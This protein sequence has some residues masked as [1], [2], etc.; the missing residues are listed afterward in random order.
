M[1][2]QTPPVYA[3]DPLGNKPAN[4]VRGERHTI[5]SRNHYDFNYVIPTYAPFYV[6]DFKIYTVTQQGAKQYLV[7]GVDYVFALRYTQATTHG[8]KV[9]YGA[10]SFLNRLFTGE[11]YLEYRTVGG[12]F[13]IDVNKIAFI[14]AEW[15]HNPVSTTWEQVADPPSHFPPI[16]H[17]HSVDDLTQVKDLVDAIKSL[18]FEGGGGGGG[19]IPPGT[20]SKA[21][22]GL[23]NVLNLP[24]LPRGRGWDRTDNYYM[25]PRA[26]VEVIDSHLGDKLRGNIDATTLNGSTKNEILE[27]AREST[28]NNSK[29]LENKTLN[30]IKNDISQSTLK[31]IS[32]NYVQLAARPSQLK[33]VVDPSSGQVIQ[34]AISLGKVRSGL[35]SAWVDDVDMGLIQM[36][37][38]TIPINVPLNELRTKTDMGTYVVTLNP[39][40][41]DNITQRNMPV[42]EQ[43]YLH[44]IWHHDN[45][46]TQWLYTISGKVY[47]RWYGFNNWSNWKLISVT[48][49]EVASSYK[50]ENQFKLLA[51]AKLVNDL[52]NEMTTELSKKLGNVGPQTITNG[53]LTLGNHEHWTKIR[54]K[55]GVGTWDIDTS[56]NSDLS[57]TEALH[58]PK[59]LFKFKQEGFPNRELHFPPLAKNETVAYEAKVADDINRAKEEAVGT[60]FGQGGHFVKQVRFSAPRIGTGNNTYS[61]PSVSNQHGTTGVDLS[62]DACVRI[63][64]A[65][66]VL[67]RFGVGTDH[68]DHISFLGLEKTKVE[69]T[70]SGNIVTLDRF[71]NKVFDLHEFLRNFD[72]KVNQS[73]RRAIFDNATGK[74]SYAHL[75][76]SVWG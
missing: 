75:P 48:E 22:V 3:F 50:D 18:T 68:N 17:T 21:S 53:N 73:V 43:A 24:I 52:S 5:T 56:P 62:H 25:T 30:E 20:L 8:G 4:V 19:T 1:A 44:V 35:I 47:Q 38:G 11:V 6:N 14:Y 55:T 60:V 64:A 63:V 71:G 2:N 16:D 39:N 51:N 46:L 36:Y 31:D 70:N 69:I 54:M 37:R 32:R 67:A 34:N 12:E 33:P 28:V 23:G 10:V 57:R 7:E 65:S 59:I 41:I 58:H 29:K 27:E 42:A 9:A 15:K 61:F 74:I 66:K 76:P 40:G 45:L 49:T 72:E 26:T 13:L